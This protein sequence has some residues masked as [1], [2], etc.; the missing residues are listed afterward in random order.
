MVS[1]KD[2]DRD[3][4]NQQPSVRRISATSFSG[5]AV[6]GRFGG[7]EFIILLCNAFHTSFVKEL[8]QDFLEKGKS[9]YGVTKSMGVV[10]HSDSARNCAELL[11]HAD[12]A[13][14]QANRN[15]F[16]IYNEEA[17]GEPG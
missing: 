11:R 8:L 2:L 9:Q 6:I 15:C 10:F 14:Y 16:I 7:D 1:E 5:H 4:L 13:L 12:W 3:L 17:Q